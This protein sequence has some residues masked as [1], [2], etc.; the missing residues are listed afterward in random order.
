MKLNKVRKNR[1]C[2]AKLLNL[3]ELMDSKNPPSVLS[4]RS[5]LLSEAGREPCKSFNKLTLTTIFH[6]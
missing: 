6:C 2:D 4:M 5:R 3:L 1:G